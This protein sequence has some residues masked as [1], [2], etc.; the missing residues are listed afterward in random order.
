MGEN[1]PRGVNFVAFSPESLPQPRLAALEDGRILLY[2]LEPASARLTATL[3]VVGDREGVQLSSDGQRIVTGADDGMVQLWALGAAEPI[4]GMRH[5]AAV[6]AVRF[7]P[8]GLGVITG[9][10]DNKARVWD[11]SEPAEPRRVYELEGHTAAVTSVGFLSRRSS[12]H[13]RQ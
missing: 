7:A 11:C 2:E 4:G 6:L 8:D 10:D 12:G 3:G 1:A 5:P 13:Y 9:C